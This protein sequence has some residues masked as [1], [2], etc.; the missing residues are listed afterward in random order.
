MTKT[1][2]KQVYCTVYTLLLLDYTSFIIRLLNQTCQTAGSQFW[3]DSLKVYVGSRS[4]FSSD[5]WQG[6]ACQRFFGGGGVEEAARARECL[7]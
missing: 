7:G 4:K 3:E 6:G 1:F 2:Q 5:I